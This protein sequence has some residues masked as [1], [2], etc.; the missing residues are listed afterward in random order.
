MAKRLILGEIT[1]V[2][3]V[4][5][6]TPRVSVDTPREFLLCYKTGTGGLVFS[7][8][9]SHLGLYAAHLW[10]TPEKNREEVIRQQ[11]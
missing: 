8:Q 7:S 9:Q 11:F 3:R 5:K 1:V 10:K 4:S 6:A 2:R